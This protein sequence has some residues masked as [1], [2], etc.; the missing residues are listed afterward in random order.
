M[1][2][3]KKLREKL[4]WLLGRARY[5]HIS[6]TAQE[7]LPDEIIEIVTECEV[8]EKPKKSRNTLKTVKAEEIPEAEEKQ[9]EDWLRD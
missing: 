8:P 1:I 9:E 7:T 5:S 2:D 3:E 4:V 6:T